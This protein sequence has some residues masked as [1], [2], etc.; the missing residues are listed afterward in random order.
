MTTK[1]KPPTITVGVE[2]FVAEKPMGSEPL[3]FNLDWKKIT[4]IPKFQMFACETS[5]KSHEDVMEW[6]E[7]FTLNLISKYGNENDA[8]RAY[9]VW[10]DEKGY[11]KN[12]TIFGELK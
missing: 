1:K 8:L 7:D 6:I 11:W 2:G 4:E 9:E 12:E 10:H 3:E 5:H